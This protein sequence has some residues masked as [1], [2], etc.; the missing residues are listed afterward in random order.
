MGAHRPVAVPE[1]K[2][3]TWLPAKKSS[4]SE[5]PFPAVVALV[6]VNRDREEGLALA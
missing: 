1:H 4:L 2:I 5:Q 6:H 3:N